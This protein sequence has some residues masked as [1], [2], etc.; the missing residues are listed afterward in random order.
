MKKTSFIILLAL[1]AGCKKEKLQNGPSA[2]EIKNTLVSLVYGGGSTSFVRRFTMNSSIDPF[3]IRQTSDDK[4]LCT[5]VTVTNGTLSSFLMKLD[6]H[7]ETIFVKTLPNSNYG[8]ELEATNDGCFIMANTYNTINTAANGQK[9]LP[10]EIIK[11]NADG[12]ELWRKSYSSTYQHKLTSVKQATDGGL[13]LAGLQENGY[14]FVIKTDASGNELWRTSYE[15]FTIT[16]VNPTGNNGIVLCG[17]R[18]TNSQQLDAYLMYTNETGSILWS[19]VLTEDENYYGSIAH[20]VTE[21]ANGAIA[22]GGV[23]YLGQRSG[24]LRLFTPYDGIE[25]WNYNTDIHD[26]SG[27]FLGNVPLNIVPTHDGHLMFTDSRGY[28][29]KMLI[30]GTETFTRQVSYSDKVVSFSKTSDNGY[31]MIGGSSYIV[32]TKTDLNGN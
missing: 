23:S 3:S 14:G 9:W 17:Q 32:L 27:E 25:M 11:I 20:C 26:T 7:G 16:D 21:V 4:Y 15:N 2:P 5:G 24:F 31:V 30:S 29:R 22:V 18:K 19:K 6:S 10:A 1:T 13:I 8:A 12:A 28:M